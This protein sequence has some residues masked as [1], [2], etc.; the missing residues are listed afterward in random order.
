MLISIIAAVSMVN[1]VIANEEEIAQIHAA[2]KEANPEYAG[3]A[4]FRYRDGKLYSISLMRCKKLSDTSP[5]AKFDL[6]G[7]NNIVCYAAVDLVDLSGFKAA[8]NLQQLNIERCKKVKDLSPL[9]GLP[10]GWIRMYELPL[11]DDLTALKDM[12]L[13]HLDIGKCAKVSDISFLKGKDMKDFRMDECP[14]IT[15]I[16]VLSEMK[17]LHFFTVFKS[18]GI[19]DYSVLNNFQLKTLIFSP[20]LLSKEELQIVRDMDSLELLGTG[21]GDWS[22]KTTPEQFWARYD[23]TKTEQTAAE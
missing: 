7:V 21:W 14:L 8:T 15:D 6:T 20:E 13:W 5:L 12:P 4:T 23:A 11:V 2:L 3:D 18:T 1:T 17:N 19:E 9:A 16:S 10:I 22:K